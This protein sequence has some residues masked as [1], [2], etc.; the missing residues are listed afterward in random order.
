MQSFEIVWAASDELANKRFDPFARPKAGRVA[1]I[2]LQ[3]VRSP[4]FIRKL[5]LELPTRYSGLPASSTMPASALWDGLH[6]PH[7]GTRFAMG[8][9][10]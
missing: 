5:C 7:A 8:Q 6:L 9:S 3:R 1:S 4:H 10:N 2:S